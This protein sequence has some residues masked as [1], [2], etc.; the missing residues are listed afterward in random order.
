MCVLVLCSLH[1]VRIKRVELH[2]KWRLVVPK[3]TIP[4]GMFS[5]FGSSITS[6]DTALVKLSVK[7]MIV[8]LDTKR[9][10]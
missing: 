2:C 5:V 4:A 3:T 8:V 9:N 6:A 1:E 7:I 10:V